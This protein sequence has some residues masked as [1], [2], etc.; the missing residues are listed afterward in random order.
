MFPNITQN[1]QLLYLNTSQLLLEMIQLFPKPNR[2]YLIDLI[3]LN[4]LIKT[5]AQSVIQFYQEFD[6]IFC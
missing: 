6:T 5:T 1:L 3:F 2:I 4:R